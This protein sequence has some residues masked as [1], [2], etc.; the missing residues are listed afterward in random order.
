[1]TSVLLG[2]SKRED[3]GTQRRG[4]VKME[5]EAGV[6]LPQAKECQEPPESERK[7]SLLEEPLERV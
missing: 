7:G 2:D 3:R 4:H 6:I 1:M 5:A